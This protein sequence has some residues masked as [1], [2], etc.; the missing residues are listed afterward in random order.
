MA[1]TVGFVWQTN[2]YKFDNMKKCLR[3]LQNTTCTDW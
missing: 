2:L 3:D 1:N